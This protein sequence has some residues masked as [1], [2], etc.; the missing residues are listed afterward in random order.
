MKYGELTKCII[1][2]MQSA[3]YHPLTFKENGREY[4]EAVKTDAAQ[5][6]V[7]LQVPAHGSIHPLGVLNDFSTVSATA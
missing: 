7:E 4:T 5:N 6:V 1:H 3:S 2:S